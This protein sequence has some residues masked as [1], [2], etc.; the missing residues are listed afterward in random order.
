MSYVVVFF[1]LS[2]LSWEEIVPFVNI[3]GIDNQHCKLFFHN[4][5]TIKYDYILFQ[6]QTEW[7][8]LYYM[9]INLKVNTIIL[10]SFRQIK[11]FDNSFY[12]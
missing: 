12:F 7:R 9:H 6:F 8:T 1:V 3:G 4:L 11:Q 5:N 2:E 10:F